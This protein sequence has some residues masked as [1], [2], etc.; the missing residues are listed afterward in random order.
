MKISQNKHK[1]V[2]E[3]RVIMLIE[4]ETENYKS[5][6]KPVRLSMLA[7][8]TTTEYQ[9]DNVFNVGGRYNLLKSVVIYGAN[10]SGKT[11]LLDALLIMRILILDSAKDTQKGDPLALVPFKL[12]KKRSNEPTKFDITFLINEIRYRYG[13]LADQMEI[14]AEWLFQAKK[15]KEYPLFLRELDGIDVDKKR[16]SE[17]LGVESKTRNNALFLSV[18]A[19][20]NGKMSSTIL[21]WFRHVQPFFGTDDDRYHD[22]AI[23]ILKDDKLFELIRLLIKQVDLGIDDITFKKDND[24]KE[25]LVSKHALYENG[26]VVGE[27]SFD[28]FSEE[29]EGTKKF[30]RIISI[31]I[32]SLFCGGVVI[33]DELDAKMH[34]LMSRLV[35]DLFN[36]SNLNLNNTQLICTVHDTNLLHYGKLRR[37]QIWF[38]EKDRKSATDLYS[39]VDIKL[40]NGKSVRKDA[41]LSKEY[42]NGR[43]G[44]IP[45]LGDINELFKVK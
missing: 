12:N 22:I 45:Y 32:Q 38:T 40:E 5:F 13:F 21:D 14:K 28:F 6:N 27:K 43:F 19:Q 11:N 33:M 29:S 1:H 24:G 30:F 25:Q 15:N 17:G 42:I 31:I 10:A 23:D 20:Y 16:F 35:L 8:K 9:N 26:K 39:L 2:N 4:F 41:S 34:Q 44:A 37:D 36:S 3:W 7:S 18:V